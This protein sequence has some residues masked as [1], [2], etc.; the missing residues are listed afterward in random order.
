MA[1]AHRGPT[2]DRV[3]ADQMKRGQSLLPRNT[4]KCFRRTLT[5]G[6][7]FQAFSPFK[8]TPLCLSNR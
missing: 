8:D 5:V 1:T 4:R 3:T 7:G 2:I 6:I